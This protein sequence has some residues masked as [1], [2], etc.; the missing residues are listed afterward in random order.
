M[1]MPHFVIY[2]LDKP[3]REAARLEHR[4][5]LRAHLRDHDHGSVRVHP[6]N[7]GLG[8]PA[9]AGAKHG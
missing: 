1:T 5:A 8:N 9:G 6:F 4:A 2:A 3:H 7:W